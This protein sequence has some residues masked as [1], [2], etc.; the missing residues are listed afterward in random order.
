MRIRSASLARVCLALIGRSAAIVFMGSFVGVGRSRVEMARL[1]ARATMRA[2]RV[3]IAIMVVVG[4]ALLLGRGPSSWIHDS[5][6][7]GIVATSSAAPDAKS[8]DRWVSE[9]NQQSHWLVAAETPSACDYEVTGS[10]AELNALIARLANTIHR[11]STICLAGIFRR[12]IR[13]V[14]KIDPTLLTLESAPGQHAEVMLGDVTASVAPAVGFDALNPAIA[15]LGSSGVRVM[16]LDIRD[17]SADSSIVTPVGI[18]VEVAAQGYG[19]PPS[20]CIRVGCRD[21]MIVDDAVS[22]VVNRADRSMRNR[23]DCANPAVNALGIVVEDYGTGRREALSQVVVAANRISDTRTGD[24][25]NLVINGDVHRFVLAGN[26]VTNGDNIGIDIE[27]WY[28]HTSQPMLGLVQGNQIADIDTTTN[29]AAGSWRD[30]RCI[31]T[32]NAAGIYDDGAR[33]LWVRDNRVIDTNQ[34]ISLDTENAYRSTSELWVT[35]N[36][37]ID[38]AGTSDSVPSYGPPLG[39]AMGSPVDAGHAF[40]ALYVDAFGHQSMIDGVFVANNQLVNQSLHFDAG[41]P[42]QATV[43]AVGG[44]FRDVTICG[45][46]IV[47]SAQAAT[48]LLQVDLRGDDGRSLSMAN[49]QFAGFAPKGT[50]FVVGGVSATSMAGWE[51]L[52][53]RLSRTPGGECRMREKQLGAVQGR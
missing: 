3:G 49:N 23:R 11:A 39:S 38:T 28:S 5:T 9:V 53:D 17:A 36:T 10:S 14:N 12:Q 7:A 24:S 16:G 19:S 6:G 15:V 43:I 30:G 8:P 25:E 26:R 18:D 2:Q 52:R 35:G 41:R 34:G 48:S 13:V 1:A 21:I 46:E 40:D 4:G 45:N 27:G 42:A 31:G 44:I 47:G 37:V 50:N 32:A 20:P 33:E 51:R 22:A 29:A